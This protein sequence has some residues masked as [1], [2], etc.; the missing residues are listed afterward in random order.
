MITNDEELAATRRECRRMARNRARAAAALAAVPFPGVNLAAD[1]AMLLELIPSINRR[2]GL[3]AQQLSKLESPV[4]IAIERVLRR[5]GARFVGVAVTREMITAALT[6]MSLQLAAESAL[7]YVPVV[8]TAIAGA[9]A[10]R[11][12]RDVAYAHVDDCTR[13]VRELM[14]A[15]E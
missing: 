4:R 9:I 8:G 5:M 3:E 2:F 6:R 14:K 1:V 11:T 7:K 13:V 10:Y 12:F 15:K